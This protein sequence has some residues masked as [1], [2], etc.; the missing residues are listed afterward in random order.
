L[1]IALNMLALAAHVDPVAA[2]GEDVADPLVRVHELALLVDDDP[3][4]RPGASHG[5]FVRLDLAGQQL[6]EGGLAGAIRA[7][8][9]DSIAALDAQAE[10]PDDGTVAETLGHIL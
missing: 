4:Q 1:E 8:D 5:A 3:V 7:D 10:V 9:A 2:V 6:Q